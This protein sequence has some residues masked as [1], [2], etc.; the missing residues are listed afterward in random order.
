METFGVAEESPLRRASAP[1]RTQPFAMGRI[2]SSAISIEIDTFVAFVDM[3]II[4]MSIEDV[5]IY[6]V[7]SN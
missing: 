5:N 6:F 1:P 7:C 3:V 2:M 4:I